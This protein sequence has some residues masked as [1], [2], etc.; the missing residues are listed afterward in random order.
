[1]TYKLG[2]SERL[3]AEWEAAN[4]DRVNEDA[5]DM[6]DIPEPEVLATTIVIGDERLPGGAKTIYKLAEKHGWQVLATY[7]RGPWLHA[8]G[9]RYTGVVDHVRLRMTRGDLL[10]SASWR[11][12]KFEN[13]W[14]WNQPYVDDRPINSTTLKERLKRELQ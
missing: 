7:A 8:S 13:A 10:L 3:R 11:D 5:P 6:K 14:D 9:D 2:D 4:A 1:M 12:T